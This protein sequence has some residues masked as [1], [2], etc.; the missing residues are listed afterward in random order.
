[1]EPVLYAA[2]PM[3]VSFWLLDGSSMAR[4]Y[5]HTCADVI[6]DILA[7]H[8]GSVANDLATA[9]MAYMRAFPTAVLT[10]GKVTSYDDTVVTIC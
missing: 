2:R 3:L 6:G 8:F 5:A 4:A 9:Y 7:R 1:M 10:L